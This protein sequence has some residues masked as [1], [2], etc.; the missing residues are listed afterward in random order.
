MRHIV[1]LPH[2]PTWAGAFEAEAALLRPVFGIN[3]VALHHIGS[4]A[5]PG[6]HA[7]PVIDIL[8]VVMDIAAVDALNPKMEALGYQPKGEY[9]IPGRRF[10]MKD[11][12]GVRSH[13]VHAFEQGDSEIERHLNFAAYLRA[14]PEEAQEYSQ[15]KIELAQQFPH[16][17]DGYCEGK[18]ALI[19]A[20]DEKARQWVREQA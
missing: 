17:I 4:T 6:I 10:F 5:I 14:H 16:D 2:D 12:D 11:I 15:L 3:L 18:D 7:K 9:G 20:L 19:R 1:V 8:P 13:H